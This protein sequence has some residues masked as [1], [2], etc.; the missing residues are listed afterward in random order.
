M[1]LKMSNVAL[2]LAIILIAVGF[3]Q[4]MVLYADMEDILGLFL[5]G[6][7]FFSFFIFGKILGK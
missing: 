1:K 4:K 2:I 7:A 5:T 6:G 3:F